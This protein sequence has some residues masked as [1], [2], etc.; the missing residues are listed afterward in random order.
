MIPSSAIKVGGD[1]SL[2]VVSQDG[3]RIFCRGWR[4]GADG[5]RNAVL[6][7]LPAA[8][9]PTPATLDRLAHEYGLT[10][11]LDSAWAARPL[12]LVRE[13]GRTVLVLKDPGGELL[14][15]LIGPPLG[16]E[17]FCASRS[18]YRRR[19]VGYTNVVS[20]IKISSQ[21]ISLSIPRPARPG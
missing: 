12:E 17:H 21:Q 20:S 8:E 15:R 3:E 6:A 7:V 10:D 18:P 2:Q 13:R 16:L 4:E 5:N 1:I 19:L 9:H 11:E 14:D